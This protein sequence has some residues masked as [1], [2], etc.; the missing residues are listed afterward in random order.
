MST[1]TKVFIVLTAIFSITSSVLFIGYV[2]QSDNW[3]RVAD[4]R[5]IRA[6][7][8]FTHRAN[9]QATME[10][11]LAMKAEQAAGL[12]RQIADLQRQVTAL[13]DD[14]ARLTGELARKTNEAA[15]FEAGRSKLQEILDVQTAQLRSAEEQNQ[16]LLAQNIDLQ[17]RNTRLNSRVLDLTARST[18]LT[19]EAR[20]LQEKLY[21]AERMG[22]A[23]SPRS[24]TGGTTPAGAV[25]VQPAV[26]GPI[27]AEVVGVDENYVSINA[28]ESSGVQKG[29]TFILS[30][31][32]SY[33]G[34]LVIDRVRPNDAGGKVTLARGP[35]QPGDRAASGLTE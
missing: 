19:E 6:E 20:N 13:A 22:G 35:A 16:A 4:A 18:I 28:G 34:D 25:A 10:A 21:A 8:E 11:A 2:A 30:R 29:M 12:G 14:K 17:T 3:K 24:S 23:G 7:A 15:Q 9:L 5:G 33:V 32:G 26:R 31:N 1:L 27:Q